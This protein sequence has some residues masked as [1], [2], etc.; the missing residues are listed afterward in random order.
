MSIKYKFSEV[1]DVDLLRRENKNKIYT[2]QELKLY[3]CNN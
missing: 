1:T 2:N 3:V